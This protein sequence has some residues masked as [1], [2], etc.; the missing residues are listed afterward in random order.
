M[1]RKSE[2]RRCGPDL[3]SEPKQSG[4]VEA[5]KVNEVFPED[6]ARLLG[7]DPRE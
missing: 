3:I 1:L 4:P 2:F 5:V 7:R 6:R